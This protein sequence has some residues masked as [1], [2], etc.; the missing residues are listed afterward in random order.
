MSTMRRWT[1]L[2]VTSLLALTGVAMGSPAVLAASPT[3]PLPATTPAWGT[4]NVEDGKVV[5]VA[6]VGNT[7]VIAGTF[8][9]VTEKQSGV[10]FD[11]AGIAAF[12]ATSGRISTTFNPVF[13]GQVNTVLAAAD[14]TSV[15]V[16]GAFANRNG[17]PSSHLVRLQVSNGQ[18]VAGFNAKVP[19]TVMDLDRLGDRLFVAGHF[20]RVNG[21]LQ[22]KLAEVNAN[23]GAFVPSISA[24]LEGTHHGVGTTHVAN[25]DVSA[26]GRWLLASGNFA[27]VNGAE[28]HQIALFSVGSPTV[29]L[30]QWRAPVFAQNNCSKTYGFYLK[31][32]AFSPA[33]DYFVTVSTGAYGN[34]TNGACDSAMRWNVTPDNGAA[35][36]YW[37]DYA[38]GDSFTSVEV[39]DTAVYAG[40]HFRWLNNPFAADRAGYGAIDFRGLAALDPLNGLPLN[41]SVRQ[42]LKL[43][44]YDMLPTAQGL[45]LGS[46]FDVLGQSTR[47]KIALLPWSAR[48]PAV[49]TPS[50]LPVDVFRAGAAVPGSSDPSTLSAG[51]YD[52]TTASQ[53]TPKADPGQAFDA[54]NAAWLVD[55]VLYSAKSDGTL[56]RRSFDGS[57]F[58]AS[59]TVDLH[60]LPAFAT[61]LSQLTGAFV[62]DGR[63][64]Y[65]VA[66]SDALYM[67]YFSIDADVVGAQEF[68]VASN[69]PGLNLAKVD[70]MFYASGS[71]YTVNSA[72]GVLS[73]TAF[74]D[75]GPAPNG[76]TAVSGPGV[77]GVWWKA[78]VLFSRNAG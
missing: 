19:E 72:K 60:N 3:D 32:A 66:G 20:F 40:G 26:D 38:G 69:V 49:A 15:Y 2:V 13:D 54:V 42:P 65:T 53:P 45:W 31:D 17:S 47:K 25:I 58:G 18:P 30:T 57:T 48:L 28:R 7:I 22:P 14:G 24:A 23:T 12:D 10:T 51:R 50:T 68:T 70:Q 62:R 43:G 35:T 37:T 11:R 77:D 41:W 64:Y 73:R 34:G 33:G 55:G 8:T 1:T 4:P 16:G 21:N 29:S 9:K 74:V 52:G 63:L 56:T 6:K 71:M 36:P 39:T 59:S 44:F 76:T 78:P 67:R 61:A 75:S 5:S 46:D 27:T